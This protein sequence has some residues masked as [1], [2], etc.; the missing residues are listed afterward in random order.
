MNESS[1]AIGGPAPLLIGVTGHKDLFE[2][3]K[4]LLRASVR[5][6]LEDFLRAMNVS[7]GEARILTGL[8]EG[9]DA[10]VAEVALE[11][12]IPLVPVLP[13]PMELYC[14]EFSDPAALAVFHGLLARSAMVVEL[15]LVEGVTAASASLS[16][17][18]GDFSPGRNQQYAAMGRCLA[19][20]SDALVA[21]WDGTPA[22]P[23]QL[24]GTGHVVS[25]FLSR[26]GIV[27]TKLVSGALNPPDPGVLLHCRASRVKTGRLPDTGVLTL[28]PI[29][30]GGLL[31]EEQDAAPGH[32]T[33][34]Q[35]LL[36]HLIRERES[37]IHPKATR[38][39]RMSEFS[40]E[41]DESGRGM[42]PDSAR[43]TI[44]LTEIEK[45][46]LT[47][48]GTADTLAIYFQRRRD[49]FLWV[50]I[51]LGVAAALFAGLYSDAPFGGGNS[52]WFLLGFFLSLVS[53][54]WVYQF[55]RG[56][57]L[58][59]LKNWF[60]RVVSLRKEATD[61]ETAFEDYRAL[62]EGMRVQFFWHLAGV[63]ECVA[64]HFLARQKAGL[65]W[66]RNA[67]RFYH[68]ELLAAASIIPSEAHQRQKVA[69]ECWVRTQR[70]WFQ[71]KQDQM[72]RRIRRM[73]RG[74]L[75]FFSLGLLMGGL[76]MENHL[77]PFVP[78]DFV[79]VLRFLMAF[80]PVSAGLIRFYMEI[81]G[82]EETNEQYERIIP[83]YDRAI[84]MLESRDGG[85]SESE[86]FFQLGREAL[87]E[88]G[89]WLLFHRKTE[90]RAV[91]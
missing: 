39:Q 52:V 48:F 25:M 73:K 90:V 13:M 58:R 76:L 67:L 5:A 49:R 28:S 62:A 83:V 55:K 74:A 47:Q 84:V 87:S 64:D 15:P 46:A 82:I 18:G 30:S 75:L 63:N 91:S 26:G 38:V 12:G 71:R 72:K 53:G 43:G 14:E 21:L 68:L 65:G 66:V 37:A 16:A 9:A 81:T 20:N 59:R 69:E 70:A 19:L 54:Y 4:D 80:L 33:A 41:V 50:L 17:N 51:S 6:A 27:G 57:R 32:T 89:D 40:S 61:P 77:S 3:E 22:D 1:T 79:W 44:T 23:G 8:A 85:P 29:I 86:V 11:L 56:S 42:L 45:I 2:D 36:A 78:D 10:L 60:R 7:P 31:E 88:H 24:G 35:D 34:M